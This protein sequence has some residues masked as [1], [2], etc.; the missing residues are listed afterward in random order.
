MKIPKGERKK[1]SKKNKEWKTQAVSY[2][3]DILFGNPIVTYYD[4]N[5]EIV[6]CHKKEHID[7]EFLKTLKKN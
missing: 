7:S 3:S 1:L 5:S 4:K 6:K 2:S